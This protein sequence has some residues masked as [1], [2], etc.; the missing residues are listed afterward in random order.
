M[1]GP[2]LF[3]ERLPDAPGAVRLTAEEASHARAR[4][5]TVGSGVVLVDGSGR[6]AHA[7]L[8]RRSREGVDVAIDR[9]ETE[10]AV[11]VP[12]RLLISGLRIERL[13]W[14][15]EK[16]TELALQ[17]IV[18]VR[19]E[20]TQ[21][22]R[23]GPDAKA[24]LERVARA[25]AKQSGASRWPALEGPFPAAEAFAREASGA[26]WLL[27]PSGDPF[28]ATISSA[29][30]IAL[31]VGPEGGWMDRERDEAARRGWRIAS[32]PAGRLRAE[33]AALCAIALALSASRR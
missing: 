17:K 11:M 31:A 33:T 14:I 29:A 32:L 2:R 16:A 24:R 30:G 9:F 13:A 4:R 8:V 19:A 27:D 7:R 28:P 12:I 5:L 10:D 1:P 20:R 18:I 21:P 22:F 3:V 25:A 26:R 6:V 15:V 23:A